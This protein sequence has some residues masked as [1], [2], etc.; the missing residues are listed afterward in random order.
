MNATAGIVLRFVEAVERADVGALSA[1]MTEDH[2][3]VDSDGGRVEGREAVTEAWKGF[4][5]MVRDYRLNV[6]RTFSDGDTV[7][8]LGTASGTCGGASGR[9]RPW[10]VPA[11]WRAVVRGDRVALWQVYVNP[12]PIRKALGEGG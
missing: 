5:H 7:V 10:K 4:L 8:L 11:A 9:G 6:E 1:C 2:V 3:F 12:E